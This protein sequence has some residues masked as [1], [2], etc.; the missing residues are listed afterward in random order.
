MK[1]NN[2]QDIGIDLVKIE[3]FRERNFSQNKSFYKKIFTNSEIAYCEKFSDPYPHFA[4]KFALKEA[5]QKSI[6]NPTILNKI[7]TFH[8]DSKPKVKLNDSEEKYNFIVS[9]SHE[10]DYAI[11]IVLSKKES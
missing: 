8:N 11:A 1:S 2:G 3:R 5:T 6:D 9:L 10:S 4:G 7:E